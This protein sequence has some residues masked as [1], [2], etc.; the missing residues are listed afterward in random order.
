M[1]PTTP[2]QIA[3]SQI[4]VTEATGQNDGIPSTR[5]M[6]GRRE[7]WCAHFVAWCARQAGSPLPG[8]H[9]YPDGSNPIASVEELQ[10]QMKLADRTGPLAYVPRPGDLVFFV[11]RQGSDAANGAGPQR[12]VGIVEAVSDGDAGILLHTIEGN[13]ANCVRRAVHRYD[14]P[15]IAGY[16]LG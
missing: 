16:G 5:Y 13:L 14:D 9:V 1:S 7:P 4:G 15:R 11:D 3:I 2:L 12:H 6:A 8:D 10:R